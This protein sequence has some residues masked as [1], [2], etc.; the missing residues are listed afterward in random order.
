LLDFKCGETDFDCVDMVGPMTWSPDGAILAFELSNGYGAYEIQLLDLATGKI[1]LRF[2]GM[3]PNW[4]PDGQYIAF[5]QI[6]IADG[7]LYTS[8][9]FKIRPD[10]MDLERLTKEKSTNSGP[11]WSPDGQCIL[12][13]ASNLWSS[14][15]NVPGII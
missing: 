15:S 1:S 2:D 12:F 11:M 8:N 4:S 14:S 3:E 7:N 9:I 6:E 10:G 13:H 5:T